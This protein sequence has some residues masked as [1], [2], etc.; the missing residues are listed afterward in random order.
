MFKKTTLLHAIA[1]LVVT[2]AAATP[3]LSMAA[4]EGNS[5][6]LL[7]SGGPVTVTFEGSDAAYSSFLSV[8]VASTAYTSPSLFP[9]FS[10]PVGTT[11]TLG[12]FA[13]GTPLDV[14]LKVANTGDVWHTGPASSNADGVIHADVISNWNGTGRTYVGFEDASGGGDRD[15]NDGMFSFAGVAAAVPV[16]PIPE[17]ESY[18]MLRAGLGLLGVM[19]QRKQNAA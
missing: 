15:F 1:S 8:V 3:S 16:A 17:P 2:L 4:S 13:A 14:Q 12:H 18:A 11:F 9:N 10:T 6:T 19:V 7:A 5:F